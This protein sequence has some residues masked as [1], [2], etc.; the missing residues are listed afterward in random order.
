MPQLRPICRRA[1]IGEPQPEREEDEPEAGA[2]W[3]R[4][5]AVASEGSQADQEDGKD[6]DHRPDAQLAGPSE[7]PPLHGEGGHEP[8][9]PERR[10]S[11]GE[12]E[13]DRVHATQPWGSWK[14][15]ETRSAHLVKAE[16]SH[17][18]AS[19]WELPG[20]HRA[21][22]GSELLSP[23]SVREGSPVL[24]SCPLAVGST[25]RL[26]HPKVVSEHLGHAT[27]SITLER[28]LARHPGYAGI[29]GGA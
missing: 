22:Q 23:V 3:I 13:F 17:L 29:G 9:D 6:D 24:T 12:D 5:E 8:V 18:M 16:F 20:G 21:F 14:R 26:S 11:D 10:P 15:A 2:P 4:V 1:Q 28:L 19:S 27:V 7:A 25:R